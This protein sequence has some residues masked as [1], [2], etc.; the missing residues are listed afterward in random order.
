MS[1]AFG[2]H[3]GIVDFSREVIQHFREKLTIPG[4][5]YSGLTHIYQDIWHTQSPIGWHTDSTRDGYVTQGLILVNDLKRPLLW[6]GTDHGIEGRLPHPEPLQVKLIKPGDV[7]VLD[8]RVP[9][10]VPNPPYLQINDEGLFI[11]LAWDVPYDE[12]L[13]PQHFAKKALNELFGKIPRP[14]LGHM[15]IEMMPNCKWTTS[16]GV[17]EDEI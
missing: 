1:R 13:Q 15:T 14:R 7:Y 8:G 6:G 2:V 11:F 4:Y 12:L 3:T 16:W 9:H 10:C 5:T 17:S